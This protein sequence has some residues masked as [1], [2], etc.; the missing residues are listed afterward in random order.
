[1]RAPSLYTYFP[2]KN[3]LYDA[4]YAQAAT[5]L[6]TALAQR[7]QGHSAEQTLRNRVHRFIEFCTDDPVRYQLIFERT[8][9]GF[10]PSSGSFAITV[11]ALSGTRTDL[12]AVG[13]Q[14]ERAL[15]LLRGVITGLV[16]LQVAND[17]GGD[18]WTRLT[19][20]AVSMFLA[21]HAQQ[22][23]LASGPRTR[24]RR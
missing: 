9:P 17:P 7:P 19:D 8:I 4:M 5:E 16:S 2:S 18:R 3:A 10:E 15:D 1:M 21:Y 24:R 14:G 23:P 11:E 12:E 13:I 6:A 20:D 22:H